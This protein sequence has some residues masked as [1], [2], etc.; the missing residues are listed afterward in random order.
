MVLSLFICFSTFA[1]AIEDVPCPQKCFHERY[2]ETDIY[3]TCKDIM[4]CET[5]EYNKVTKKCDFVSQHEEVI[6]I[7]C[8]DIDRIN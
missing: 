8:R 4:I 1:N 2:E 7:N 3:K 6:Y 5:F